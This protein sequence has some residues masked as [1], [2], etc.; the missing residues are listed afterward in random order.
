M[1]KE[2][3]L[4]VGL[5]EIGH[6]LSTGPMEHIAKVVRCGQGAGAVRGRLAVYF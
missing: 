4:I 5:G 2:K 6:T 3:V 1:A